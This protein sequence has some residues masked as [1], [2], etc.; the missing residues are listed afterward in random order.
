MCDDVTMLTMRQRGGSV[1]MPGCCGMGT[2][3]HGEG[4][5]DHCMISGIFSLI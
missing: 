4:P 3:V 1:V 2:D 5:C